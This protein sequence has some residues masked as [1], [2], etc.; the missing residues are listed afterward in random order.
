MDWLIIALLLLAGL[1]LGSRLGAGTTGWWRAGQFVCGIVMVGAVFVMG[2]S[3]AFIYTDAHP[4]PGV[5][6]DE[7]AHADRPDYREELP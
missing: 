1:G 7:G 4:E 3:V 2:L 5:C 6:Q